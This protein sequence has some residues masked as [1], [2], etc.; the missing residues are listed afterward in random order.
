MLAIVLVS[1]DQ[2]AA[3][4]EAVDHA[5][6]ITASDDRINFVLTGLAEGLLLAHEGRLAEA[7]TVGRETV[8]LAD[9]IDYW[10]G[11]PLAHSYF[12][13]T[14]ALVGKPEEAAPH[15][16]TA[17]G[18]LEGKGDVMLAARVRERLAVVGIHVPEHVA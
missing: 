16:A 12:A 1:T 13:E 15:A 2:D 18:I 6:R 14:L 17:L 4:R 11:R 10:F 3:A 5:R 9:Q 8:E 7:E